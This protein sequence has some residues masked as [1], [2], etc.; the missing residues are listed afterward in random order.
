MSRARDTAD[1]IN[2]INSSAADATAITVDSSE[3]VGIGSTGRLM[4]GYDGNSKTLTVYDPDGSAQ[5]GYL[6]LG[7]IANSNGH[8]A[9]AI[10]FV[11][12]ANSNNSSPENANS[13]TVAQI[14][15]ETV[16]SDNNAGD[17][18]GSNLVI[19]TKPEAG[20]LAERMR[21][22]SS[23]RLLV[24]MASSSNTAA[25][26]RVI[27]NDFMS[28]TTTSSDAGDR[29][30]LLNRQSSDG[31]LLEFKKAN[32]NV[33][34]IGTLSDSLY[35]GTSYSNDSAL[36]FSGGTIHPCNSDG[37][38]RDNG[39]YLG[40]ASGRFTVIY[41][42]NGTIQTSDQTEKQDIASLT[43]TEILVAKRI[44]AMFKNYRWIDKVTVEG[45]DARTHTGVIAQEVQA[46]FTAEGLDASKYGLFCSDTWWEHG[47]NVPAVEAVAEVTETTTD[48]DGNEV[49]TVI[50]EAVEAKDAYIRTEHYHV[51]AEAPEGATSKTRLGIRYPELLSFVAAYN[52][53]RFASIEARLTALEA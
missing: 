43:A 15:A 12:N 5:S 30:L 3:N 8:N 14:R 23:G 34:F 18:A 27:P 37:S 21:I 6:E 41:A 32:S 26:F 42:V 50:T 20:G 11:N 10:T 31:T 24:G 53:Q 22:D 49:V 45:D 47:V 9:G 25:G 39:I 33:G 2:R 51:E 44:S 16:T 7:A 29:A 1:Q 4:S 46:A 17:D 13:K 35:I 36:R 48:E 40:Y 38:P 52:E 19:F 28:F